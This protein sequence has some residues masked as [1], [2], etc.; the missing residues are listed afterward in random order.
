MPDILS[1]KEV[2]RHVRKL[3]KAHGSQT[4]WCNLHRLNPGEVYKFMRGAQSTPPKSL[5][6]AANVVSIT[7][8]DAKTRAIMKAALARIKARETTDV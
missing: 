2:R 8:A 1:A 4:A 5:C 7:K 3:M 6:R